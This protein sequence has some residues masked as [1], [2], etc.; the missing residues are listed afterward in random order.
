MLFKVRE[1]IRPKS[2]QCSRGLKS[3]SHIL[4]AQKNTRQPLPVRKAYLPTLMSTLC[5]ALRISLNNPIKGLH[6]CPVTM[7]ASPLTRD[8]KLTTGAKSCL[9]RQNVLVCWL[10]QYFSK[11]GIVNMKRFYINEIQTKVL[12]SL[13]KQPILAIRSS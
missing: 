8:Y 7:L 5:S 6:T 11:H 4:L 2:A 12:T 9:H 1:A 10:E 3:S 13:E